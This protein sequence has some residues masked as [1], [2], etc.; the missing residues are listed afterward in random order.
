MVLG[1]HEGGGRITE[2]WIVD[3]FNVTHT[4]AR[5]AL[6]RLE[7][8]GALKLT[9]RRGA[10]LIAR[11]DSDPADMRPVWIALMELAVQ[12][13]NEKSAVVDAPALPRRRDPWSAYKYVEAAIGALCDAGGNSR[14]K[15]ALMRMAVEAAAVR[16]SPVDI[17]AVARLVAH[18]S[19]GRYASA[20]K[21]VAKTFVAPVCAAADRPAAA[22]LL[23]GVTPLSG[24]EV[25]ALAPR[26]RTYLHRV[27]SLLGPAADRAPPAADQVAAAIRQR[28][29]FG[30]LRP[31]DAVREQPLAQA[32]GVSRG[33]VRDALR[34]LDR[35]GLVSLEGRKGA[36][37]RRFSVESAVDIARV[38]AVISG[39][40]MA[41]AAAAEEHPDW[42]AAELHEGVR[43]L[44]AIATEKE[45][46]VG[47]Y[48]VVRRCVAVLTLAAGANSVVGRIAAD[49]E[50]E[51][52]TLW[53]TV[54]SK[55]RQRKSA[56][57]WKLIVDAII[58]HDV[59]TARVYGRRI[60]EEA[61]L[62]ALETS[63][64]GSGESD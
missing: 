44:N 1:D 23:R 14:L 36:F 16:Q 22:R 20:S 32:F 64:L 63:G 47:N 58:D 35:Q 39:V 24:P 8:R 27:A 55:V 53:A 29:Q 43:L 6:H 11:A 30:E 41:E 61:F 60:V 31:G 21:A 18:M 28:I 33:P 46:S 12:L 26:I 34:M 5:E 56:R 4:Q 49:L 9:P 38:R 50:S 52:T 54:L 25:G 45:A 37:V 40:Q 7:K 48:I 19:E 57:T 15:Q 10:T 59:E 13:A 17:D 42:L 62:S 3:E 51:I 2:R